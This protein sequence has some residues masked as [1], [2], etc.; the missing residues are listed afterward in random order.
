MIVQLRQQ[1]SCGA[2]FT[3]WADL[4]HDPN[5][6]DSWYEQRALRDWRGYHAAACEAMRREVVSQRERDEKFK[7]A[8][9][10]RHLALVEKRRLARERKAAQS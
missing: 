7:Q 1:C 2:S 10:E 9:R 3:C 8:Y 5:V 6:Q 4:K